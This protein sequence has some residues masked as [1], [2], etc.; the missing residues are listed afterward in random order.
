MR[1]RTF[2][3]AWLPD[4]YL[5]LDHAPLVLSVALER[6]DGS[7]RWKQVVEPSPG[8][9]MHH[10]ELRCTSE[11]DDDVSRWLREAWVAAG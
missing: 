10:I 3:W 2:A 6:R 5:G 4:R 7:C 11:I 1:R 8:R 9:F